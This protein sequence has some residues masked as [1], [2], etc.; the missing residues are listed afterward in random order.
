MLNRD[1]KES[2]ELLD[3]RGVLMSDDSQQPCP[4]APSPQPSPP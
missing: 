2:V 3:A 1:F 4:F